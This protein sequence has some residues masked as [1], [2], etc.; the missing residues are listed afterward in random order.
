MRLVAALALLVAL[1]APAL[2]GPCNEAPPEPKT[3][4]LP[5]PASPA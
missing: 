2:A 5:S 4:A 1:A 3:S